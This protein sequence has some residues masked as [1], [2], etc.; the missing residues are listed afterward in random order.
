MAN[1]ATVNIDLHDRFALDAAQLFLVRF[2][3]AALAN[4]IA[5]TI[6]VVGIDIVVVHLAN[7]S[8]HMGANLVGVTAQGAALDIETAELAQILLP[9]RQFFLANLLHEDRRSH[10]RIEKRLGDKVVILLVGDAEFAT[11][12]SRIVD[13]FH[14][15]ETHLADMGLFVIF[16]NNLLDRLGRL[17]HQVEHRL[18]VNQKFTI[19]VVDIATRRELHNLA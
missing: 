7:I 16:D 5:L 11:Q 10:R 13:L 3:E 12:Q 4:V 8:Q 19:A 1:L 15:I 9:C 17:D 6:V 2:F 18:I 14:L